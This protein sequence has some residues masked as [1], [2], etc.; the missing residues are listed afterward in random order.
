[1]TSTWNIDLLESVSEN[2]DLYFVMKKLLADTVNDL[3]N[4]LR[5]VG[6]LVDKKQKHKL[7]VLTK[8]KLHGIWAWLEHTPRKSLKYLSQETGCHSLVQERQCN[9]C[10]SDPI[11]QQQSTPRSSAIQLAGFNFAVGF[12]SM[13]L[14][15]RLIHNWHYFLLKLGFTWSDT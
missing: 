14:K 7:W 5:S 6:L 11:K 1:M 10:C 8:E 12:H 13:S 15:V 2:V 3:V 4:K 9:S